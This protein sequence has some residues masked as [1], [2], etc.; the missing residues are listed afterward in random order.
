MAS[1]M[2]TSHL[3]FFELALFWGK[4]FLVPGRL[5]QTL[6]PSLQIDSNPLPPTDAYWSMSTNQSW[7]LFKIL[8]WEKR[9]WWIL[10]YEDLEWFR[11]K[12]CIL[13][14][15]E[16]NV[17][18]GEDYDCEIKRNKNCKNVRKFH[19]WSKWKLIFFLKS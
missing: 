17:F 7:L 6:L 16:F 12:K 2:K 13:Y 1:E 19:S 9:F 18:F 3:L 8:H 15:K 11:K 5:R 10:C 14:Q 4:V